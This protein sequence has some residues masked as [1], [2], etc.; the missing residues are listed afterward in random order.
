MKKITFLLLLSVSISFSQNTITKNIGSFS[1]LKIYSGLEVKIQKSE[2][3]KIEITGDKADNVTIKNKNG[4]LKIRLE[5]PEGLKN[6][7]L[8]I[9]LFY[10]EDIDVLDSNEGGLIFSEEPIEQQN[11]EIKTQEGARIKLQL[12]VKYLTVKSVSGGVISVSGKSTHQD[13]EASTGGVYSGFELENS[14]TTASS[15]TGAV[16]S[17]N[18]TEVLDGKV[19]L[20]GTIYFKGNPEKVKTQK[21]LGGSFINKGD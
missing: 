10:N 4:T 8:K 21:I 5:F 1:T 14:Q 12:D 17:V 16:I 18:V 3:S 13:I 7:D 19:N 11:L 2:F 6:E 9:T 15:S 20:G